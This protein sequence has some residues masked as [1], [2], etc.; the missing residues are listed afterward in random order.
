MRRRSFLELLLGGASLGQTVL[1]QELMP[2]TPQRIL[3]TITGINASAFAPALGAF[4][5][6]LVAGGVPVNLVVD[7]GDQPD[8]VGLGSEI[9]QLVTRYL[10]S[11]PG[12]VELVAWCPDLGDQ[13]PFHAARMASD[14]RKRTLDALFAP[15]IDQAPAHSLLSVACKAP[16][17]SRAASAALASGFRTVVQLPDSTTDVVARLDRLGVLSLLGGENARVQDLAMQ[18][19]NETPGLQRHIF[20][21][22]TDISQTPIGLLLKTAQAVG[23]ILRQGNLDLKTLAVLASDVQMRTNVQYRRKV[24][25]LVLDPSD[26]GTQPVPGAL[27]P[28]AMLKAEGLPFSVA[29][30]PPDIDLETVPSMAFWI[31]LSAPKGIGHESD[32]P[33]RAYSGDHI[34][35]AQPDAVGAQ[36]TR[37]GIVVRPVKDAHAAGLTSAAEL[38]IPI[39]AF[40]DPQSKD[41]AQG[42][43]QLLPRLDGLFV[44]SALALQDGVAGAALTRVLRQLKAEPDTHLMSLEMFCA[45]ILPKDPLLPPLLLTRTGAFKAAPAPDKTAL[46]NRSALLEDA[47]SAWGY[48]AQNTS[49]ATGLCPATMVT[50]GSP[51]AGFLGVSMWEVGS[52]INALMAAAD[53]GLIEEDEFKARCQKVLGIV[54]RGSRKRL[55]LP[56]ES[57]D[58]ISGKATSWFNSYD[59]G[60]LMIALHR[61]RQ[62]RFAPSGVDDLVGLWDFQSVLL[63]RRLHSYKDGK[64]VD[65]FASNYADYAV[66]GMRLWGFDLISPFDEIADLSTADE[67][68]RLLEK[69]VSFGLLGAEPCLL[70]LLEMPKSLSAT[71]L[72]D[73][74]DAIQSKLAAETGLLAAPSETPLDRSPW[75]TYQGFDIRDMSEPWVVEIADADKT[76]TVMQNIGS[77]RATSTKAAYLWHALRPNPHSLNLVEVVRDKARK[78]NGF[79]SALYSATQLPTNG[80]T[81]LNTNAV[82]LQS[83]AHILAKDG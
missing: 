48:F 68:M 24:G 36:D 71:F 32:V 80:Y 56:P 46:E 82:I 1:A 70:H 58:A 40:L 13:A 16:L 39:L 29:R 60:R 17:D 67:E 26:D 59:T 42:N 54:E 7:A 75:F 69:T 18:L 21:S 77:L 50:A 41:I 44:V 27:S 52:H 6:A 22:S 37:F 28:L 30:A 78:K 4:L 31:P 25:V 79:D 53:L 11:F 49:K 76:P 19:S 3:L 43:F 57:I 38:H 12:L 55:P 65:D 33:Y 66:H 64:T 47:Q 81:D 14:T 74:L 51:L 62:H 35:L 61:L 45:E 83:I 73:C 15:P 10:Q 63:E 23:G 72:A 20:L 8:Q 34:A 9:A 5:A 2:P